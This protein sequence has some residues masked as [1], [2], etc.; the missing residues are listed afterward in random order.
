MNPTFYKQKQNTN[1][2][3]KDTVITQNKKEL[4][5]KIRFELVGARLEGKGNLNNLHSN[6]V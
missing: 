6:D 4:I 5:L 3:K 2:S 1:R